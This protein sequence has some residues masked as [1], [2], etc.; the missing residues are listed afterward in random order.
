[1]DCPIV[2]QVT[3]AFLVFDLER[4]ETVDVR[5]VGTI[6]RS[7]GCYP[8]E[9]ELQHLVSEM[10]GEGTTPLVT[11]QKF[12]QPVCGILQQKRFQS[13]SE[14]LILSAFQVMD[15]EKKGTASMVAPQQ[16]I[17]VLIDFLFSS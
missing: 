14:D 5:E 2:K 17:K 13:A 16:P 8:S 12:V 7:L 4:N 15:T 6:I 10:E 11:L 1:M 3:E 9:S